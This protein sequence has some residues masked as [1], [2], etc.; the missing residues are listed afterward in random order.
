M[1]IEQGRCPYKAEQRKT[2][3]FVFKYHENNWV[4][5]LRQTSCFI[6]SFK[7]GYIGLYDSS[8]AFH[9]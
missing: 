6:M 8:L 3:V 4:H 2:R 1:I 9:S 7:D 5:S